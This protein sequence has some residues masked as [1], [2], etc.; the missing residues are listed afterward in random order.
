MPALV[1][2][3][4]PD[5]CVRTGTATGKRRKSPVWEGSPNREI[6]TSGGRRFSIYTEV[7]Y[8][9]AL[10]SWRS[11]D[12]CCVGQIV[13]FGSVPRWQ[14]PRCCH[15]LNMYFIS[16]GRHR[17]RHPPS[18]LAGLKHI[19]FPFLTVSSCHYPSALI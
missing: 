2:K 5:V 3:V 9:R 8:A 19:G 7:K 13:G 17:K 6:P 10:Q 4:A 1:K 11:G 16:L 14:I 15:G 12:F 18:R